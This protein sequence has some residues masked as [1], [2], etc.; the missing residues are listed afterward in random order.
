MRGKR[1]GANA[2]FFQNAKAQASGTTF[3]EGALKRAKQNGTLIIADR[4]LKAF[5]GEILKFSELQITENWWDTFDLQKIDLSNNEIP[6]I[7][8]EISAQEFIAWFNISNNK[9]EIVPNG[10][11]ALKTLKFLDLSYNKIKILPE[12]I[13]MTEAL[14]EFHVAGNMLIELPRSIGDL[15]NLEILDIKKNKLQYLPIEFGCLPR[16]LK[17]DLEDNQLTRVD[18]FFSSLTTLTHLNLSKNKITQIDQDA[19]ANLTNLV[20]LDMHQNQMRT[21]SSVPNSFKLDSLALAYN[22]I[23]QIQNLDRAANLSVLDLHNNKLEEFPESIIDLKNLKTLKISNNNLSDINPRIS[24]LPVLVRI[25]IEG[26]PLKCI[27]STMRNAGAD[28]LKKYL[29]MRLDDGEVQIEENKQAVIKQIPGASKDFDP[30]DILLREFI[31]NTNLSENA[32]TD[33]PEDIILLKNLK[34]LRVQNNKLKNLPLNLLKMQSLQ[35]IQFANNQLI[36]FY[37]DSISRQEVNL[38]N[39]TFLSLNANNITQV[40][41]I[42]KYLPK[43]QQLHLH[44]NKISDVKELCRKQ[45]KQLEVLDLGNNK[46]R[47]IPIALIHY[48]ENLTLLNLQNNDISDRGIPNLI[49]IHKNIKTIQIDGN[50][51]KSIRRAIIEKGTEAILKYLRDKFVEERDSQVEEWAL[52]QESQENSYS[53]QD[54]SYNNAQ[55]QYSQHSYD[56]NQKQPLQFNQQVGRQLNKEQYQMKIQQLNQQHEEQKFNT[57]DVYQA[58]NNM[59]D[60]VMQSQIN[61][62]QQQFMNQQQQQQQHF[63]NYPPQYQ[64][65]QNNLNQQFQQQM[66]LQNKPLDTE[67]KFDDSEERN[68]S[69]NVN[70]EAE[71]K[72]LDQQVKALQYELDNNFSLS[73]VQIMDKK[74]LIS[75]LQ[76]QKSKL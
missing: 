27:K 62:Q 5:P 41:P 60:F 49:G 18:N 55:Y 9:I 35:S 24:L 34:Q 68:A 36:R 14:V 53:A 28:Q 45:F 66:N 72:A 73:K 31:S 67:M 75:K 50:P 65:Q 11:L 25:T 48:C 69:V 6:E 39:L 52:E 30:W 33:L 40:P 2:N 8:E 15:K 23:E 74:K 54:Y 61:H 47:E 56:P 51:L 46:L 12:A 16:I 22:F 57:K 21:F 59:Q 7:P 32:F 42:L 64:S 63:M 58:Q 3:L 29:K 20:E 4:Q 44:M 26:N 71:K 38:P 19:L 76:A 70:V 1:G 37:D 10:L 13:A 17:L 43:L